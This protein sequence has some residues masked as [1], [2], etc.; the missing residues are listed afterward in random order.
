LR[1]VARAPSKVILTGEHFVVHGAEALAAAIP[2]YSTAYV[3]DSKKLEIHS[4]CF[5]EDSLKPVEKT[6]QSISEEYGL[7]PRVKIVIDSKIPVGS[8]LGSSAS[9]LVSVASAFMKYNG[10][11]PSPEK[12]AKHAMVGEKYIHGNPSGI[13]TAACTYGKVIRFRIGRKVNIM[14]LKK[15]MSLVIVNS[16]KRR[17]TSTLVERFKKMKEESSGTFGSLAK[18]VDYLSEQVCSAIGANNLEKLGSLL[19]ANHAILSFVGVSTAELD[20]IVEILLKSGCYG[21][22]LT[23]AGGG[24][25]VV[26][27]PEQSKTKE[28]QNTV[29]GHGY[30]A[31]VVSI[32]VGGVECW[33][34]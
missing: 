11:E 12:I 3:Y 20:K 34:E 26:A 33:L 18:F 9:V 6:L 2:V 23:G 16:R 27:L 7:E 14:D 17:R 22:K 4:A 30:D 28:I 5:S 8:G 31:L 32:P 15:N 25:C 19:T 1:A 10:I 13:D 21:A 24:G 29:K